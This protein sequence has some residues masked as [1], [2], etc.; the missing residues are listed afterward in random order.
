MN[1]HAKLDLK[2]AAR[3][4][5]D[6]ASMGE[7][8]DH[9]GI[10][11][12]SVSGFMNRNRDLFPEKTQGRMNL[13][14]NG[15]RGNGLSKPKVSFG[16][17]PKAIRKHEPKLADHGHRGT[18]TKN[19][20]KARMEST[21]REAEQFQSGTSPLL[22]IAP[23]DAARLNAGTGKELMD[24]GA[25]ECKWALTN[26]GPWLFCAESTDGAVYCE[27]HAQRAY[28]SREAWER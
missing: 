23:D 11:R 3:M 14:P 1:I 26:G 25:H 12:N 17:A 19:T 16:A 27:H 13:N 8:A 20:R 24:L 21:R 2:S 6:D 10:S 7:I 18:K 22:Q 15:R 5:A 28:R 4:W 9:F